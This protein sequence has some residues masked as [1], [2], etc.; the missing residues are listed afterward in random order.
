MMAVAGE[1]SSCR[2]ATRRATTTTTKTTTRM[3]KLETTSSWTETIESP[4][5]CLGQDTAGLLIQIKGSAPDEEYCIHIGSY[6]GEEQKLFKSSLALMILQSSVSYH[7][8]AISIYD[9]DDS[10]APLLHSV[11]K[12]VNIRI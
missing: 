8:S 9:C 11:P 12:P 2:V 5:N 7:G 4:S 3:P 6:L 1:T 10:L